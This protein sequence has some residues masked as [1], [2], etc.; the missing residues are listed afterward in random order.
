MKTYIGYALI[1]LAILLAFGIVGGIEND[2]LSFGKG[3]IG[4]GVVAATATIGRL[5]V[6]DE[7]V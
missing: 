2:M 1:G 7:D 6:G 3:C 5:L 4:V